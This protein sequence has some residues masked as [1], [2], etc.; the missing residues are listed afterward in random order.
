MGNKITIKISNW[1]AHMCLE[2]WK[3]PTLSKEERLGTYVSHIDI[4][5]AGS[6]NFLRVTLGIF[7]CDEVIRGF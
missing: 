6:F 3:E 7:K 1:N 4:A 5:M 2:K